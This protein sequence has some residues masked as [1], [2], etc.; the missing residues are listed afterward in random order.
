MFCDLIEYILFV[1]LLNKSPFVCIVDNITYTLVAKDG[2]FEI[3]EYTGEISIS[4]KLDPNTK[5]VLY[6]YAHD[7]NPATTATLSSR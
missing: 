7:G 1:P 3:D 2:H 4:S 5:Y 6:C